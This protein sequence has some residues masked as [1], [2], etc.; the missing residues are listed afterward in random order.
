MVGT[1]IMIWREG[2]SSARTGD[3][4]PSRFAWMIE[5]CGVTKRVD[6][7]IEGVVLY[8]LNV[9]TIQK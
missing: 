2:R 4:Q 5:W 6:E 8:L 7:R 9:C 1:K 3:G